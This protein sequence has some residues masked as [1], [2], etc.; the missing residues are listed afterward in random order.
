[1]P[2]GKTK[3]TK[4]L[5]EGVVQNSKSY[6]ETFRKLDLNV[7]NATKSRYIKQLID[8]Y[9]IS[10]SHFINNSTRNLNVE[11]SENVRKVFEKIRWSD[12]EVFVKNSPLR[13]GGR[14]KQRLLKMGWQEI[15][16]ECGLEPEWNDKPLVLQLDHINGFSN[17]NRLENLRFLCPNCHT[18]TETYSNKRMRLLDTL[19]VDCGKV[20]NRG[21]KRCRNCAAK[22]RMSPDNK[23]KFLNKNTKISWPPDDELWKMVEEKP[24]TTVA[25]EL[26]VSDNAIR[27]RLKV[28]F[29]SF[30]KNKRGPRKKVEE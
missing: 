17:D 12:E 27:K 28:R 21:C 16:A 26:G 1:M 8:F 6:A 10:I 22:E 4:E 9:E 24:F 25:K 23:T 14:I 7:K 3:Y 19:C 30:P 13:N 2:K 18:Q 5:L 20:I 15:C 29:G 11:T